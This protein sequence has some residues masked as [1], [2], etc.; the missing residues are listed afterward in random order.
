[1]IS[2]TKDAGNRVR[3]PVRVF[4]KLGSS[5]LTPVFFSLHVQRAPYQG[6]HVWGNA[7]TFTPTSLTPYD[8]GW[9]LSGGAWQPKWTTLPEMIRV[10][11]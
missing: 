4:Q 10:G 3:V 2:V 9:Y 1:M 11:S 7:D 8:W 5:L 6:R